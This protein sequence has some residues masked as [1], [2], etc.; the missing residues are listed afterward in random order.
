MLKPETKLFDKFALLIKKLKEHINALEPEEEQIEEES[1]ESSQTVTESLNSQPVVPLQEIVSIHRD[2]VSKIMRKA[3]KINGDTPNPN[4]WN[5]DTLKVA[6]QVI[7]DNN[8]ENE[9]LIA[10][11]QANSRQAV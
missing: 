5:S 4:L 2:D 9:R 1:I 11:Y 3:A 6:I 10:A 8:S 7:L